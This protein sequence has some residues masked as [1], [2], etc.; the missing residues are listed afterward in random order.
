MESV[1]KCLNLGICII[2]FIGENVF[3]NHL[4][5]TRVPLSKTFSWIYIYL[6]IVLTFTVTVPFLIQKNVT[7]RKEIFDCWIFG[8]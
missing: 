1:T 4:F 2:T 8:V 5:I 7:Y 3:D 6:D